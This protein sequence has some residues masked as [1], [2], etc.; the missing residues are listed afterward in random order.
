MHNCISWLRS[1]TSLAEHDVAMAES[2]NLVPSGARYLGSARRVSFLGIIHPTM[3]VEYERP[4][5]DEVPD[6]GDGGEEEH[7]GGEAE[8]ETAEAAGGELFDSP[9]KLTRQPRRRSV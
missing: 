5:P 1:A 4:P 3:E 6:G 7:S 8:V 9:G 2:R